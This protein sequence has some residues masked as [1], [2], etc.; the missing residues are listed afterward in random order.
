LTAV[1]ECTGRASSFQRAR[2]PAAGPACLRRAPR[3]IRADP[4][5]PD[6]LDWRTQCQERSRPRGGKEQ[7]PTVRAPPGLHDQSR[8]RAPHGMCACGGSCAR[9]AAAELCLA[10][11][12]WARRGCPPRCELVGQRSCRDC[13]GALHCVEAQWRCR[14]AGLPACAVWSGAGYGK[15]GARSPERRRGGSTLPAGANA[16]S[17]T[18]R[19]TVA[20][21]NGDMFVGD[22]VEGK[23]AAPPPLAAPPCPFPHHLL[24]LAG[25]SSRRPAPCSRTATACTPGWTARGTQGS[26]ATA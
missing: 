18:G 1:A 16:A 12:G 17:P 11:G 4:T 23:V 14:V 7:D 2:T 10:R 9:A 15:V 24:P 26:G 25:S 8:F 22:I 3:L 13:S 20:L 6:K 21:P 19:G 5:R